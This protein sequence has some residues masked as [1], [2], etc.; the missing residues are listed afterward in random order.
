MNFTHTEASVD[1][2]ISMLWEEVNDATRHHGA[3]CL[4]GA[5]GLTELTSPANK[6]HPEFS[7][8]DTRV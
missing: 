1:K 2:S 7:Q 4:R 3:R 5:C 6:T 8:L